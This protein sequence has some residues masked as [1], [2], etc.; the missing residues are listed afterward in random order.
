MRDDTEEMLEFLLV[1]HA[2]VR[3]SR[4]PFQQRRDQFSPLLPGDFDMPV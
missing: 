4:S 3:T 2:S 1:H